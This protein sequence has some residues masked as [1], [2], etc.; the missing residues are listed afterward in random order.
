MTDAGVEIIGGA[1]AGAGGGV[2]DARR[3]GMLL[4]LVEEEVAVVGGC[5][6][7]LAVG[8]VILRGGVGAFEILVEAANRDGS[9]VFVASLPE[10]VVV[11]ER[12][13]LLL[14]LLVPARRAVL[15]DLFF[16]GILLLVAISLLVGVVDVVDGVL[17]LYVVVA[18]L[19]DLFLVG[20]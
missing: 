20:V 16:R 18:G 10:L 2:G 1:G 4:L 3:G 15:N 6:S 13:V 12:G 7:S 5:S 8:V 17:L 19:K 14:L 9:P 11:D